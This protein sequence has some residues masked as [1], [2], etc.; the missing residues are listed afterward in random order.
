MHVAHRAGIDACRVLAEVK[1]EGKASKVEE[2]Q[3]AGHIVAMVGDGINDAPALAQAD[4]GIAV[5]S[6]TDVAI[7][8]ADIVLM[9]SSIGDVCTALDLSR[10]VMRRIH[11]NFAWAFG[12][13]LV[14]IP[15]ASGILYPLLL[16]QLPPMFAGAAMALSSVSVVCSSLLLHYYT[17]PICKPD[18][19]GTQQGAGR[20]AV[21][22][23][24]KLHDEIVSEM[25]PRHSPRG[26]AAVE[27][28]TISINHV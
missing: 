27:L 22:R 8:A 24:G 6:G 11:I 1:P 20:G 16:I 26:A 7:E 19:A 3:H 10:T 15:F 13:N 14:G 5:G 21:R 18:G 4:V 2:L 25:P 28:R 17:P 12:Y 9:K 23:G